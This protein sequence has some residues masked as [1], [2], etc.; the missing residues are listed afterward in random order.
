MRLLLGQR[1]EDP[2]AQTGLG[3][4]RRIEHVPIAHGDRSD[5]LFAGI[6]RCLD[7]RSIDSVAVPGEI[8]RALDLDEQVLDPKPRQQHVGVVDLVVHVGEGP[9]ERAR[10]EVFED[11]LGNL[12]RGVAEAVGLGQAIRRLAQNSGPRPWRRSLSRR[13][14]ARWSRP[15]AVMP[16]QSDALSSYGAG[17]RG[18][19]RV[20]EAMVERIHWI[21]PIQI[22]TR[23]SSA[24]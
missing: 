1:H 8:A 19:L 16:L 18:S 21:S 20:V 3:H 5:F 7:E 4:V 2:V 24:A 11:V 6:T 22:V 17:A 9:V 10:E 12:L 23:A 15:T 13:Y 14:A